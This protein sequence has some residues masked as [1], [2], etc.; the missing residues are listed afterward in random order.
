MDSGTRERHKQDERK[1]QDY[2][3]RGSKMND[4]TYGH[5]SSLKTQP[6]IRSQEPST[7]LMNRLQ[8]NGSNVS[9]VPDNKTIQFTPRKRTG[10]PRSPSSKI[11]AL[12]AKYNN[13]VDATPSTLPAGNTSPAKSPIKALPREHSGKIEP[14]R[15]SLVAPSTTNP[16]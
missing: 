15:D 3:G 11:S 5:G 14:L 12:V 2:A 10:S 7:S 4:S 6:A 9:N 8:N 1:T 13:N 16:P